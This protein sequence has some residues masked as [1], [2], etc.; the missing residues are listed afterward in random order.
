MGE[1]SEAD[2]VQVEVRLLEDEAYF[3]ELG[4]VESELMDEYVQNKISADE[5]AKLERRLLNSKQQQQKLAFAKALDEESEARA[6][7]KAKVVPIKVRTRDRASPSPYLKL[8]AAVIVAFGLLLSLWWLLGRQSDVERGMVALNQAQGN[9]RLIQSRIS[10]LNYAELRTVRGGGAKL[11]DQQARDHSERLLLD[12]VNEK[13][14]A[15]SYHALGRL[16]LAERNFVKAREQFEKA[17][18]KDPNDSQLQS[19]MGAALLELGQ[20]SD[21]GQR[22]RYFA[23]SL[24]YLDRALQLNPSSPEALFNRALV[25]QH[26]PLLPQAKEAWRSYL[27]IDSTSPWAREA[28]RNL[29]LLEDQERQGQSKR[30]SLHDSFLAA[31]RA[32]DREAAWTALK[33]SRSRAGNYIV[34]KLLD[35]YLSL[36]LAGKQKEAADAGDALSFAADVENQRV[37]DRYT[38]DLVAFYR[39]ARGENYAQLARAR[40]F[41]SSAREKYDR[42]EFEPSIEL[43]TEAQKLFAAIGNDCEALFAESWIGYNELRLTGKS[44]QQRFE[45]LA[46]TYSTRGYQSLLAQS[47]HGLSDALTS[48]NEFSKVLDNA[49]RALTKAEEIDDE[50]TR[51]RCL[52]QFVS[53]N[54][55]FG[56]YAEA[57]SYGMKALAVA[58]EF[59]TEP[60]LIWTFYQEIAQTLSRLDLSAAA[61]EFQ[62]EASRLANVA[63]WPMIIARSYTQLGIILGRRHEFGPAIEAGLRAIEEGRKIENEKSR[64]N[65]I[66]HAHLRLAEIYRNA[67]D[68][69]SALANYDQALIMFDQLQQG[70]FLYDARK[71][72]FITY[73]NAGN[74][75]EAQKELDVALTLFELYRKK[76]HE[77]RNRNAFFDVGQD[78]YD[79]A[80]DFALTKLNDKERAFQY[81]E[82]S[83]ARALLDLLHTD[84][85]QLIDKG[86][87]PDIQ[88]PAGVD[89]QPVAAMRG[90]LPREVAVVEY[91]MLS[92]KLIIFVLMGDKLEVEVKPVPAAALSQEILSYAT[93]LARNRDAETAKY[94]AVNL[95]RLLIQPVERYFRDAKEVCIVPDKALS[96]L[97][98]GALRSP[99]T[100]K[101]LIEE[102]CVIV[103]PS[104]NVF[105]KSTLEAVKKQHTSGESVLSVGNP[106]FSRQ[107]FP[108]LA[109]LPAAA[110]EA[111]QVAAS[112]GSQP[113]IGSKANEPHVRARMSQADVIHFAAHYVVDPQSPL[114]STLLLSRAGA[115]TSA[116]QQDDGLLQASEIYSMKLRRTRLAVLSACQTGLERSYKG[117]GAIGIARSFISAEVPVVVASL[118]PVDSDA[119]APLMIKFHE[120]RSRGLS[121]AAALQKAQRDMLAAADERLH[122]PYAWAGFVVYGGHAS[123]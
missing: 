69:P 123:F 89:P 33:Q 107:S 76:I 7:A 9:E 108:D 77:E 41:A 73:L 122:Q 18:Q 32:K 66:S 53:M 13:Q 82:D 19:D 6:T 71:G 37:A 99:D 39:R 112:Y 111:Q 61:L 52:Q 104:F 45:Q 28:E 27:Q 25:Y 30:T 49:S 95:Y 8:A 42:S 34:E 80:I 79:L 14:D 31:Y 35:E 20:A 78:I 101:F 3:E 103:S 36:N 2:E 58:P 109:D 23:E 70:M 88:M 121:S 120:Y 57:L 55:R 24:Q 15:A 63:E 102:H 1:L 59:A 38:L 86:H 10:E 116:P 12:A 50:A 87:G 22:L 43:L 47:L 81:A 4:V 56:N 96:S 46:Q 62:R 91:V 11:Q 98:F 106:D 64:L 93:N 5:R 114:K 75:I 74:V 65:T 92:N 21:D 17:L 115:R 105:T 72:K 110:R 29:K 48:E 117:E 85:P 51:L 26:M 40:Q 60:K 94:S 16:Y 68:Y 83:R 67:G 119:T 90:L 54:L 113:L 84:A 100:G 97:P 44:S 118:W